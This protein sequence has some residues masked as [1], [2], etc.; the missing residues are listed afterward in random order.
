M[1]RRLVRTAA[2][3]VLVV[4]LALAGEGSMSATAG[5]KRPDVGRGSIAAGRAHSIMATPD[6]RVMAWG[7]GT[8]GQLGDGTLVNRPAPTQLAGLD[9]VVEVSAGAAHTVALTTTGNVY[10]WG[11]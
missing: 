1:A 3:I 7:A 4:C 11:A 5:S 9:N 10:A 8:R 2:A 6:G